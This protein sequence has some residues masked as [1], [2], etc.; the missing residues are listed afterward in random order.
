M[1]DKKCGNAVD[2]T[3]EEYYYLLDSLSKYEE[4]IEFHRQLIENH[5]CK[6]KPTYLS[7]DEWGTW[8][9]EDR[10]DLGTHQRQTMRDAVFAAMALHIFYRNSDIVK[11]AMQTQLCNLN[12]SL[13]DTDGE[14][15]VK[16]A[17]FWVMKLFRE[18]LEGYVLEDAFESDESIDALA[19]V[20]E[21]GERITVTA[22]NKH[23]YDSALLRLSPEFADMT[24]LMSDIVCADDVRSFNAPAHP[25]LIRAY[26]FDTALPEVVI[27]PHSVIRIV[28]EK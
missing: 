18:H 25:D 28:L 13:F 19:S 9:D 1:K 4:D 3:D 21:D 14:H 8:H 24:V 16:T 20:S 27:P 23:L 2:Y 6:R 11:M 26:P 12:Q 15:F 22:A 17:T 5:S 10:I 7:I